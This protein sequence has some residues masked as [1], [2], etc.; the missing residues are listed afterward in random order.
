MTSTPAAA[1]ADRPCPV[2][3]GLQAVLRLVK[4]PLVL[5][6]CTGCR[7]VFENPLL[8]E[9]QAGDYYA[10]EGER[11]Y[12][13][14]DKLQ[15]DH[16][17][18]R[19]ERE[20]RLFRHHCPRGRVLDVGCGTGGFLHQLHRRFPGD[21]MT[22]GNDLAGAAVDHA[23]SLGVPVHRGTLEQLAANPPFDAVTFWAVL[24][25]LPEPVDFLRQASRLLRPGG[26]CVGLVPNFQSLAVRCVGARYRYILPQHVNYFTG[27]TLARL[28]QR[29][30]DFAV[31][32]MQT[33]HFNP[34]VI[35]Q[36][37]RGRGRPVPDAERARLLKR[38]NALKENARLAPLQWGYRAVERCLGLF[39]LGDNVAVIARKQPA[40]R[41]GR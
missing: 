30:P 5:T 39:R 38:T 25:H 34:V 24:E 28:F 18:V 4:G 26:L 29:V 35:W 7:C 36:D 17:P 40:N 8:P 31:C 32:G 16:S 20:L 3:G 27:A 14:P 19:Y 6:R 41:G 2:C 9:F 15:S 37:F 13:S 12:L 23:E 1:L 22:L 33:T 21:Y 11:Y 10:G